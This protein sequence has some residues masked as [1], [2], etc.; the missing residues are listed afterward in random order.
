MQADLPASRGRGTHW[1]MGRLVAPP[2]PSYRSRSTRKRKTSPK[3]VS[4]RVL[5]NRRWASSRW[6]ETPNYYNTPQPA[7]VIDRRRPGKSFVHLLRKSDIGLFTEL[8]PGW[9]RL[10][11]GLDAIVLSE[12]CT[13]TYGWHIPG[14]IHVG[15]WPRSLW[16]VVSED[17][18]E[19]NA[20][21]LERLEV[22]VT[23]HGD[24]Y[25]LEWTWPKAKAF[26]LLDVF[27][28]ELGHHHDRMTTRNQ[29][30]IARGE[31][32]ADA[33]AQHHRAIVWD[34]YVRHFELD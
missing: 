22:E 14:V 2:P 12:G 20:D 34:D 27:L 9:N 23:P 30:D 1:L 32:F 10:S 33:F 8:L 3:A 11:G 28:H 4:A 19:G 5:P 6:A 21:I 26:Q 13:E 24:D 25:V 15:A 7:P 31:P 17:F 18:L 16:E 29:F